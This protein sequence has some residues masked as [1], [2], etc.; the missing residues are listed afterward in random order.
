M[1]ELWK[2]KEELSLRYLSQTPEER[3]RDARVTIDW[4]EKELGKPIKVVSY[5]K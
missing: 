4:F 3:E 1:Q 2:I 5:A